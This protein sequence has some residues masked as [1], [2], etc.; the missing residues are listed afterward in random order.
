MDTFTST[1]LRNLMAHRAAHCVSLYLPTHPAG[2]ESAQDAVRL[3]NLADK[4][5]HE[6]TDHGMRSTE[7]RELLRAVRELPQDELFWLRR[8]QGLALFVGPDVFYR[9]RLPERF[10]EQ[11]IV[12]KRFHLKP[13]IPLLN[14]NGHY[15]ILCLS[16]HKPRLLRAARHS[17]ETV[18]VP[19][20]PGPIEEALNFV[21]GERASQVHSAM[22]GDMSRMAGKKQAAVFHGQGGARETAKEDMT[23]YFR[24]ID[25]A[26]KPQLRSEQAP[27]IL[28]GVEYAIPIFRS[29]SHYQHI[30]PETVAGTA[31]HWTPT[32]IQEKVWPLVERQMGNGC[33]EAVDKFHALRGT[34]RV[35]DNISEIAPA[36]VNGKV[37][38]LILDTQARQWGS[39]DPQTNQVLL[40][41]T[42]EPGDEDLIDLAAVETLTNRGAVFA[43]PTTALPTDSP[44]A[45]VFRY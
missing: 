33:H 40:R 21:T 13:L 2:T 37:D 45:A 35:S 31:D 6:L 38:C 17:I 39:F 36:A 7:A 34:A 24:M 26:I 18:E 43:V 29:V 44:V 11:V 5:V 1:D 42:P 20:M 8:N 32:Q 4:A 15:W 3:K 19:G 9:Y 41:G 27:L 12:N 30:L 10:G 22:R 16:Q 23:Q 14:A 28:V 25:A